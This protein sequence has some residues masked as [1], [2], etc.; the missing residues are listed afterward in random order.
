M[1]QSIRKFSRSKL[2]IDLIC[3][4][5]LTGFCVGSILGWSRDSGE[6]HF[7]SFVQCVLLAV[8]SYFLSALLLSIWIRREIPKAPLWVLVTL[9]GTTFSFFSIVLIPN[10]ISEWGFRRQLALTDNI[11]S[12]LS[13]KII[14][15]VLFNMTYGLIALLIMGMIHFTL[16]KVT[17]L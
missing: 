15:I 8:G 11:L 13:E 6:F 2:R 5:I 7:S 16:P 10:T 12:I 9:M 14:D 4:A 1:S 17:R 3:G